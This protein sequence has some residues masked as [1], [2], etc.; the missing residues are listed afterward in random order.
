M[1]NGSFENVSYSS[2]TYQGF[3]MKAILRHSTKEAVYAR[4]KTSKSITVLHTGR[5]FFNDEYIIDIFIDL[6]QLFERI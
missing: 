3:S 6:F 4:R 5:N 1:S 2:M